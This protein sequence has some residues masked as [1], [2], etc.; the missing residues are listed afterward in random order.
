MGSTPL[1]YTVTDPRAWATAY[2]AA[3]EH[4]PEIMAGNVEA[5]AEWFAVLIEVGRR[6]VERRCS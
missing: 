1:D 3:V 4:D 2:I 5:L 6:N